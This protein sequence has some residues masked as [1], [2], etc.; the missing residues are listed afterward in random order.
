ML[1]YRIM[2]ATCPVP[3]CLHGGLLPLSAYWETACVET[4]SD[5]PPGS[6]ACVQ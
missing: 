2:D 5:I 3:S 1:T 6:V 4:V